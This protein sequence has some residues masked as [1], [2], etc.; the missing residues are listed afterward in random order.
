M[1]EIQ[2][3]PVCVLLLCLIFTK[4]IGIWGQMVCLQHTRLDCNCNLRSRPAFG[5]PKITEGGVQC[6]KKHFW[7]IVFY[8]VNTLHRWT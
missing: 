4:L 7:F 2:E 5:R 8:P 1:R 6:F 3:V